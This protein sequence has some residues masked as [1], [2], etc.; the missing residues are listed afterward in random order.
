MFQRKYPLDSR[1]YEINIMLKLFDV[2]ERTREWQAS[3]KDLDELKTVDPV[4]GEEYHKIILDLVN[5]KLSENTG[6]CF[7]GDMLDLK[8]ALEDFSFIRSKYTDVILKMGQDGMSVLK[9][10]SYGYDG[11]YV[12]YLLHLIAKNPAQHYLVKEML[13]QL[14]DALKAVISPED[15]LRREEFEDLEKE[16]FIAEKWEKVLHWWE[17][18]VNLNGAGDKRN[19]LK[20]LIENDVRY[21]EYL[22]QNN[23]KKTFLGV[24]YVANVKD[25][26]A[27]ELALLSLTQMYEEQKNK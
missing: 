3:V 6:I 5:R 7:T 26:D 18:Y 22:L 8:L 14:F 27:E 4:R 24:K 13:S 15:K 12:F 10:L 16:K 23:F 19:A 17:L 1:N 21:A 20:R 9:K 2:E 25:D 11:E